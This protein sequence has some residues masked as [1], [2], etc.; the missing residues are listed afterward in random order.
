MG[1]T[2]HTFTYYFLITTLKKEKTVANN[3]LKTGGGHWRR[4]E[5]SKVKKA[6]AI[7][8]DLWILVISLRKD[9]FDEKFKKYANGKYIVSWADNGSG[10]SS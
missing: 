2:L 8:V 1:K 7:V 5:R 6:S 3:L 10:C 9:D 4:I